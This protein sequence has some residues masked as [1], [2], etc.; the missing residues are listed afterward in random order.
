VLWSPDGRTIVYHAQ[1]GRLLD[2]YAEPAEGG[3][4]TR[5]THSVPPAPNQAVDVLG[6]IQ[7]TWVGPATLAVLSGDSIGL[8][9]SSGGP[10]ERVCTMPGTG[11]TNAT[12]LP[13]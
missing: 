1:R 10:V 12:V 5:L 9:A 11:F 7:L 3:T 6:A 2:V 13:G 4:P 8:V